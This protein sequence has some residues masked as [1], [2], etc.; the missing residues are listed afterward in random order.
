MA[1]S[2]KIICKV[3]DPLAQCIHCENAE[4]MLL[5]SFVAGLTGVPGRQVGY[6]NPQML[7][8][9]SKIALSAQEVEKQKN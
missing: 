4:L 6:T 8:Q 3:Y 5:A 9:A 2:Q 7:E 1:L